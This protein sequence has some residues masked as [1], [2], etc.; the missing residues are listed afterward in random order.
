[1]PEVLR[2]G[3]PKVLG[4]RGP[5]VPGNPSS[6][7]LW[8]GFQDARGLRVLRQGS[9]G[10]VLG[11]QGSWGAKGLLFRALVNGVLGCQFQ[12][13]FQASFQ[14]AS[15][16]PKHMEVAIEVSHIFSKILLSAGSPVYRM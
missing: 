2:P 5:K 3:G 8:I 12:E 14:G 9:S 13:S 15:D 7:L 1:V 11:R 4:A 16:A 10:W 6:G